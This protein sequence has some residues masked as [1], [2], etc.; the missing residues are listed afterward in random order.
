MPDHCRLTFGITEAQAFPSFSIL[1]L[2][3]S[4]CSKANGS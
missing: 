4:Y 1:F 3:N 2:D